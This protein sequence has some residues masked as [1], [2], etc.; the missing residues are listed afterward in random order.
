[1]ENTQVNLSLELTQ[2]VIANPV[3]MF[4]LQNNYLG[5]DEP[6]LYILSYTAFRLYSIYLS[7]LQAMLGHLVF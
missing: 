3:H 5:K 6:L 2:Q 7:I 1:M 4:D